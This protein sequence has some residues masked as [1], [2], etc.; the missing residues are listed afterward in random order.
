VDIDYEDM[1]DN[2]K[3]DQLLDVWYHNYRGKNLNTYRRLMATNMFEGLF[4]FS[5]NKEKV[6]ERQARIVSKFENN[7]MD[8]FRFEMKYLHKVAEE[9]MKKIHKLYALLPED[10][11]DKETNLHKKISSRK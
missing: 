5:E 4:G 2:E 3:V 9:V 6:F 10:H 7:P 11:F 1:T 8:F